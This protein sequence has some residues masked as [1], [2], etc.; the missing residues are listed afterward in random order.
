MPKGIDLEESLEQFYL[1]TRLGQIQVSE[2]HS[3]FVLRHHCVTMT[4][5]AVNMNGRLCA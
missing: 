1:G 3:T 5:F 4:G 2:A